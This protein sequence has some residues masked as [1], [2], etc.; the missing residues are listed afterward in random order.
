M[1][2]CHTK[3]NLSGALTPFRY[4]FKG[5]QLVLF[6]V[7]LFAS[8][9]LFMAAVWLSLHAVHWFNLTESNIYWIAGITLGLVFLLNAGKYMEKGKFMGAL[10]P[11]STYAIIAVLVMLSTV[12]DSPEAR[13]LLIFMPGLACILVTSIWYGYFSIDKIHDF[14][15]NAKFFSFRE[16]YVAIHIIISTI[17]IICYI[18]YLMWM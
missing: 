13:V 2:I 9:P 4:L 5:S 6:I 3:L 8:I 18:N 11:I 10:T 16:G 12:W 7:F 14:T 17:A 1:N 15:G